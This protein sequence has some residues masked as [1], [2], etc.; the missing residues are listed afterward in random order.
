VIDLF[1]STIYNIYTQERLAEHT[2]NQ[3]EYIQ[4]YKHGR[5]DWNQ[6]RRWL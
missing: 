2:Y 5:Y 1:H 3:Y 4:Y 6:S